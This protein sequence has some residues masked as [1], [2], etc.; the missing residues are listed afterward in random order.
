MS[1]SP[2]MGAIIYVLWLVVTRQREKGTDTAAAL[3]DLLQTH[4]LQENHCRL[5][6]LILILI[7]YWEKHNFFS[8][9][10]IQH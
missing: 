10:V 1:Y 3:R 2:K 6:S 5:R 8:V 7:I 4:L 9:L